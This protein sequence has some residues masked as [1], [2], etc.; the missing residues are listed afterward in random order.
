MEALTRTADI[1][2]FDQTKRPVKKV[3]CSFCLL[4]KDPSVGVIDS[5]NGQAI[6]FECV[7]KCNTLI[8]ESEK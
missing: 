4:E 1:I 2:P 8:Q 5:G 7:T 3:K 6:C